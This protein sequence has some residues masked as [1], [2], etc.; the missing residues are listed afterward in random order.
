MKLST[1]GTLSVRPR[2]SRGRT[3]SVP[4]RAARWSII[5]KRLD[6]KCNVGRDNRRLRARR[7]R[8]LLSGTA[9]VSPAQ[10]RAGGT[11]AVPGRLSLR[12]HTYM[13]RHH[14]PALRKAHPG[15]HLAADLAGHRAAM[16]QGGSDGDV[17][18]VGG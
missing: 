3:P 12:Y 13:R 10:R 14:A 1:V 2:L 18:A 15:L 17:A 11:P 4:A 8:W 9:G 16:E 6:A 7:V 5:R